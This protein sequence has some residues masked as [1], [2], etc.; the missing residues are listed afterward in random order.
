[1]Y[2]SQTRCQFHR[3]HGTFYFSSGHSQ[4]RGYTLDLN[5]GPSVPVACARIQV[6][7]NKVF[8]T[9]A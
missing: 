8:G 3:I 4:S 6:Y 1:M 5:L 2:L 9:A 7:S